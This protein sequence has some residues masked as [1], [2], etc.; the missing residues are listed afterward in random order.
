MENKS[1]L[2]EHKG[3]ESTRTHRTVQALKAKADAKRTIFE[4]IADW[5]NSKIGSIGFLILNVLLVLSWVALNSGFFPDILPFDNFPFGLLTLILSIEAILLTIFVLI[6]QN[7]QSRLFD[8]R[9]EMDLQIDIITELEMTKL[10]KMQE[11]VL[12]KLKI[13]TKDDKELKQM[14]KPTYAEKIEEKLENQV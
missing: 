14:E 4:K 9:E 7:R 3:I 2:F 5:I 6:S 1:K 13:E 12:N 10:L 11:Q 8:L